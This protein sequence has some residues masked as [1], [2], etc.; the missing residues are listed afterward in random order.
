MAGLIAKIRN[1]IGRR[2]QHE[3][4]LNAIALRP[5]QHVAGADSVQDAQEFLFAVRCNVIGHDRSAADVEPLHGASLSRKL[6][7][8]SRLSSFGSSATTRASYLSGACTNSA[9]R[10]RSPGPGCQGSLAILAR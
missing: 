10:V 2:V 4:D 1:W 6:S 7:Q 9:R 8:H 5:D 3:R